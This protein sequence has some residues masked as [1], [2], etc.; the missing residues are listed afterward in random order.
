MNLNV[1]NQYT[2]K[3][4]LE[5]FPLNYDELSNDEQVKIIQNIALVCDISVGRVISVLY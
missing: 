1:S 3:E 2:D 5:M 4:I